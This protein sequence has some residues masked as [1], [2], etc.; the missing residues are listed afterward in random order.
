MIRGAEKVKRIIKDITFL[1]CGSP[2]FL[3]ALVRKIMRINQICLKHH[4][5]GDR[6]VDFPMNNKEISKE[7]G[8]YGRGRGFNLYRPL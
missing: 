1:S 3:C 8:R 5:W 6:M 4:R 7:R 2:A